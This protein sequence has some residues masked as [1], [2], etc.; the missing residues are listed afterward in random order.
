MVSL[1]NPD[2]LLFSIEKYEGLNLSYMQ[3]IFDYSDGTKNKLRIIVYDGK[4]KMT[5]RRVTAL[6]QA[7]YLSFYPSLEK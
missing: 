5:E 1:D 2:S 6:K 7:F 4:N 3:R